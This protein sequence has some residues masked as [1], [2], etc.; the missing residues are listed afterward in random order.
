MQNKPYSYS[1]LSIYK[2]CPRKYKYNYVYKLKRKPADRSALLKGGAVHSILESYP[3]QSTHPLA[4]K[5]QY[6]TDKFLKTELGFNYMNRSSTREYKFAL[7]D[8]LE[9]I[10]YTKEALFYG[11]IDYVCIVDDLLHLIDWKT[12]KY[13]DQ[14]WQDYNQLMFYAIYFFKTFK[15]VNSIKISYVYVEH[16]NLENSIILERK[17][18][19]NYIRELN[20]MINNVETDTTFTKQES[21][22]C[23]WCDF[24]D[25]CGKNL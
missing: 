17:Y 5:I 8:K 6:I 10:P 13:K 11:I 4:S 20:N 24:L 19:D 22:L 12:G 14:K 7:N 16:E 15:D 23:D 3:I 1:K 18:L 9:P 2:Q 25:A 21:P